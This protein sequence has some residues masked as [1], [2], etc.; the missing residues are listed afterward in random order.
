MLLSDVFSWN[1]PSH[2]FLVCVHQLFLGYSIVV[3]LQVPYTQECSSTR[4][5]V[6]R[7]RHAPKRPKPVMAFLRPQLCCPR[8]A[9]SVCPTASTKCVPCAWA[10]RANMAYLNSK[11]CCARSTPP[12]VCFNATCAMRPGAQL[13]Q[14]QTLL[15]MPC[16]PEHLDFEFSFKA[17]TKRSSSRLPHATY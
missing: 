6:A 17:R 16:T 4:F 14:D 13:R 9:Q 8:V 7:A 10:P 15:R 11:L 3:M 12:S 2:T 1:V 5:F